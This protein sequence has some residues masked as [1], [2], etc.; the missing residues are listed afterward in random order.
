MESVRAVL[1]YLG[2]AVALAG[3]VAACDV[4]DPWREPV[5]YCD[6]AGGTRMV[7]GDWILS[8]QGRRVGCNDDFYDASSFRFEA[9]G[10]RVAQDGRS[11]KLEAWPRLP[12]T[13]F[14]LTRGTVRGLCVHFETHE[15]SDGGPDVRMTFDGTVTPEGDVVGDFKGSGPPGCVSEGSFRLR[16]VCCAGTGPDAPTPDVVLYDPDAGSTEDVPTPPPDIAIV[17]DVPVAP[18]GPAPDAPVEDVAAPDDVAP[19]EVSADDTTGDDGG[20]GGDGAAD[21]AAV[22]PDG[23]EP[24]PPSD[25][26]ATPPPADTGGGGGGAGGGDD[27][28]G[29]FCSVGSRPAAGAWAALLLLLAGLAW[30]RALRRRARSGAAD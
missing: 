7:G 3:L 21:D 30:P 1:T 5:D 8:G 9:R 6:E 24:E 11:L 29:M 17:P 14:T 15:G 10:F 26:G 27:T 25:T 20:D 18:D 16:V 13:F 4:D 28:G 22:T 12:G 2:L 19:G 23:D